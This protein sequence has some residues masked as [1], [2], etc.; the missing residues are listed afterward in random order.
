MLIEKEGKTKVK[1]K[2][3]RKKMINMLLYKNRTDKHK[4]TLLVWL[5]DNTSIVHRCKIRAI[6]VGMDEDHTIQKRHRYDTF[7]HL[8]EPTTYISCWK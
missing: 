8:D 3:R 2:N 4:V 6:Q 1:N 7:F 5:I